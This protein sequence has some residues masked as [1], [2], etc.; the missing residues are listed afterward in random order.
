[1]PNLYKISNKIYCLKFENNYDLCMNFLRVQEFY[2]S[3]MPEFKGKNFTIIDYMEK[4]AYFYGGDVFTYAGDW[5]GFNVPSSSLKNCLFGNIL[6]VNRYDK[7]MLQVLHKITENLGKS[8]DFYLIGITSF[9]KTFNHEYAHA[10]YGSD[11]EYKE[12]CNKLIL[13]LD[14]DL[15]T[16]IYNH[17]Q[18]IGYTAEV[19]ADEIQAYL[20]TGYRSIYKNKSLINRLY[21]RIKL[22]FASKPFIELFDKLKLHRMYSFEEIKLKC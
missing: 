2:E 12:A 19:F 14:F 17:L 22:Y 20:S 4:Y 6:D 3:P 21:L 11:L 15:K 13:N 1:M 8:D 7:F 9:D 5:C 10:L 18:E 16:E